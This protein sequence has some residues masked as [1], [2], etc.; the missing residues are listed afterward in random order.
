MAKVKPVEAVLEVEA[1]GGVRGCGLRGQGPHG[2][3][4]HGF[5]V[6]RMLLWGCA[7]LQGSVPSMTPRSSARGI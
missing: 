6:R 3:D 1:P 5:R 7:W 4:R 2:D